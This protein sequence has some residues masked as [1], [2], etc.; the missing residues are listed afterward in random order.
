MKCMDQDNLSNGVNDILMINIK[1]IPLLL[2]NK[3][4]KQLK[5]AIHNIIK[6]LQLCTNFILKGAFEL[7][8]VLM[9]NLLSSFVSE[10]NFQ[11]T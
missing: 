4:T 9:T 11:S 8:I 7:N 10:I 1:W 5:R 6:N 3:I 2:I